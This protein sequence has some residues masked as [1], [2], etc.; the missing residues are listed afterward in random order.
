MASPSSLTLPYDA[1]LSTT[2]FNVRKVLEDA[3]STSNAFMFMLM[4]RQDGGY[5]TVNEIGER[6]QIPLMYG[7]GSADFYDSY[8]QLDTTPVEDITSAFFDWRQMAVP[9]SISRKEER[10]NSGEARIINL[11]KGK[12]KQALLGIQ[13]LF[14]K[15]TLQ[16][17]GINTATSVTTAYSSPTLGATGVDPIGLLI[18]Y[19]PTSGTV[20]NLNRATYSWWRNQTKTSSAS[21]FSG[22]LTELRNLN[23]SCSKGPGGMPKLHLAD[24]STFEVY[25]AALAAQHRNPSYQKADIPYD[26]IGFRGKPVVWDEF[27]INASGETTVQSTSAGTWYMINTEFF[28]VNVDAQTNFIN[29]GFQRPINQD[30]KVAHILWLGCVTCSNCRKQ[31]VMGSIDTTITS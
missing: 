30:A 12:T 7:L 9:I 4:R 1:V 29:T 28:Q 3:I 10:M 23:N 25:E 31:G 8:D 18:D 21:S 15:A 11:L 22:F 24:Q 27:V 17:D 5:R 14:N 13:E 26:S 2:L 16:G 19:V 6:C 20:G